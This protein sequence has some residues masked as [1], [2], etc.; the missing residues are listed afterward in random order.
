MQFR[1]F[2]APFIRNIFLA[3]VVCIGIVSGCRKD[4]SITDDGKAV[5][6]ESVAFAIPQGWP[7]PVYLFD[8]NKLTTAG[9]ELGRKIFFDPRLSRDSSVSCGSCH[10][11]FAAFA[12]LD[13]PV[14]HGFN[15]LL[16]NRNSPAL[17]NLSWHSSF[18][19]DGGVNH[20]ESQPINPMQNPVEM[21]ETIGEIVQML[22]ADADYKARFKSA[23]GDENVN[24]QRIFK[25]LAQFM[26]M[27]VSSNS[28]YDH[29]I[30]GESGGSM[31]TSEL[32]G[33]QLYK[34]NCSGCHKDPLFSDF[35]YRNNGLKPTAVNDSGRAHVTRD[36]ADMYKFKVP[37]LRNL[38]YTPPYMHDGRFNTL[39]SV[40]AHYDHG[41]YQ[42]PTLDPALQNGIHF[43]AQE[44]QDLLNFL[45]TLNDETFVK[46]PR[47]QEVK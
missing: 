43:T 32:N 5:S 2:S 26:C 37:S 15:N 34:A 9:F 30:R 29:Y 1:F 33:L 6:D 27:L 12:Q 7:A 36:P 10:Q 23:F 40:L 20:I 16:G 3:S 21:N 45:N 28:K 13:H 8:N 39:D 31:T 46:D 4:P 22:Q 19:W 11:P 24:S 41:I 18:F 38:K 44:K 42:S 47:F 35:S 17:F 25:A 14:S